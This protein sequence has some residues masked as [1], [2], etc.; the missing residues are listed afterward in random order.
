[1]INE[2]L[3]KEVSGLNEDLNQ[4]KKT[5]DDINFERLTESWSHHSMLP[6]LF[7]LMVVMCMVWLASGGNTNKFTVRGVECIGLIVNSSSHSLSVDMQNHSC[8]RNKSG[9]PVS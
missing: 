2:L 4:Q 8:L 3:Q 9:K 7:L 6:K 1:M 5:T